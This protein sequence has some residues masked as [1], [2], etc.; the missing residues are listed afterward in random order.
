MIIFEHIH[1]I[2]LSQTFDCGQCFRWTAL[3]DGS[4]SGVAGGK[5]VRVSLQNGSLVI[6]G[7]KEADRAFWQ[8]YFDLDTDY[9]AIRDELSGLHPVLREAAAYAS[10]I[11]ILRQEPFEALCSFII[12]QNNNIPRIRGIVQRLCESFG[13]RLSD[14]AFA[15]PSVEALCRCSVEDLAPLRAGFRARY[16]KDAAQKVASGEVDLNACRTLDYEAA[17]AELMKITGVGVKVADCTLLYG[18][19]RTEAFPMDVWMKRAMS[20]LFPELSPDAFGKN[21][22]IAQQYIFHYSR[23]HASLFAK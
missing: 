3:P 4:F 6:D 5:S 14:G 10:G 7:A 11:R 9:A 20:T 2:S 16:L 15:F 19:H 12:S 13:E 23:M 21:G 1:D 17:R 22:G 18:M 8:S